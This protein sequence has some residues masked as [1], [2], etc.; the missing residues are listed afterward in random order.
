MA[1]KYP[2]LVSK[3]MTLKKVFQVLVYPI[4]LLLGWTGVS[5]YI[6]SFQKG[7]DREKVR[8]PQLQYR[9]SLRSKDIAVLKKI[10]S[11][12]TELSG[13]SRVSRILNSCYKSQNSFLSKGH[14]HIVAK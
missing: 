2:A 8:K 11:F 14:P 10:H 4:N 7:V 6:P 12:L 1:V 13:P 5:F 9:E 3:S